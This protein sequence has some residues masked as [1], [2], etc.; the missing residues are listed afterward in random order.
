[1][2]KDIYYDGTDYDEF[3]KVLLESFDEKYLLELL[4][5]IDD[6]KKDL[7]DIEESLEIVSLQENSDDSGYHKLIPGTHYHV[8]IKG[9]SI[10]IFQIIGEMIIQSNLKNSNINEQEFPII[11]TLVGLKE[12]FKKI[13]EENGELCVSKEIGCRRN[14]ID[15]WNGFINVRKECV[16]NQ[17]SC[18]H[19][20]GGK[21]ELTEKEFEK[22][23]KSL[24]NKKVICKKNGTYKISF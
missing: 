14:E 13:S 20:H 24:I 15:G 3:K 17:L 23:L 10:L 6:N 9:I 4:D 22:I 21:C 1:M 8:H 5:V 2:E 12:C 19:N 11:P 7:L 18:V 16:N